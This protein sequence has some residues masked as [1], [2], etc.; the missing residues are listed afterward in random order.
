M[1]VSANAAEP[2]AC[3]SVGDLKAVTLKQVKLQASE[4]NLQAQ[5]KAYLELENIHK[6]KDTVQEQHIADQDQI[7]DAQ[8]A[9]LSREQRLS[10]YKSEFVGIGAVI[11]LALW[12]VN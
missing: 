8:A 1:E 9:V 10:R 3:M 12:V 4:K 6:E 11:A 2:L 5:V 7:I